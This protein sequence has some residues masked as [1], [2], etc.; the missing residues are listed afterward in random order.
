MSEGKPNPSER[1]RLVVDDELAK[2]I[3]KHA[4]KIA[5]WR[6]PKHI[7]PD[8]VA[9]EVAFGLIRKPPRFDPDGKA[10]VEQFLKSCI[11]TRI[12][13]ALRKEGRFALRHGQVVE[14]KQCDK[15][16]VK[17]KDKTVSLH[18][19]IRPFEMHLT[20]LTK[21]DVI[22]HIDCDSSRALCLLFLECK[23]VRVEVARRMG[24]SEGTVR[25]RLKK[26]EAG[27]LSK[28][29]KPFLNPQQVFHV[30][31]RRHKGRR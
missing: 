3:H 24:V 5:N 25:Y 20:E 29:F 26:L 30:T 14:E 17:K 21:Q 13:S 2:F 11:R 6:C 19:T 8:D 4:L 1:P 12:C 9:Q 28:G 18:D 27:L 10:D 7:E 31:N 16:D 22:T 23:G 15:D